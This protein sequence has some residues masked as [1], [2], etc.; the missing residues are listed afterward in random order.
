MEE[1]THQIDKLATSQVYGEE[2]CHHAQPSNTGLSC[3]GIRVRRWAELE[4]LGKE[5]DK[6][7]NGGPI[8]IDGRE[9]GP[10]TMINVIVPMSRYHYYIKVWLS[11]K[12]CPWEQFILRCGELNNTDWYFFDV[13]GRYRAFRDMEANTNAD[14][15]ADESD[16]G[17]D[18]DD[19]VARER[20]AANY[21]RNME[22][23]YVLPFP[24]EV[25]LAV[26]KDNDGHSVWGV[27]SACC[28]VQVRYKKLSGGKELPTM[29]E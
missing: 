9:V 19:D 16:S 20:A 4:R 10:Y 27:C 2:S 15:T 21:L 26:A 13:R 23:L 24:K 14:S 3:T 11:A 6:E 7:E 29:N 25:V 28:Q 8:D 1:D 22:A 18:D 5:A 17:D 12:P